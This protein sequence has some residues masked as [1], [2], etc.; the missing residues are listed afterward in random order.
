[1]E[2]NSLFESVSAQILPLAKR[3]APKTLDEVVGQDHILQKDKFLYR[4]IKADR[5]GSLIFYG[6]PGVGKTALAKVI[7]N[8]T[9]SYFRQINAVSSG[10]KDMED[11]VSFAKSEFTL[12]GKRT[13]LFI[14]EIHRFNKSQ[15]DYLLPFVENGV[16]TL[17]GATTENPYFEVNKAL[18][19]R[20]RVVELNP[21]KKEDIRKI[22]DRALIDKEDGLGNMDITMDDTAKDFLSDASG[23]DARSALNALE[24]AAMTTSPDK[25]SKKII[26]TLEI[27]SE[28]LGKKPYLYDKDGDTHYDCISAFI[29]SMRGSDENAAVYYLARMLTAGEDV[30]FIARRMMILASEDIGL[31]DPLAIIVA[32]NVAQAVERV[33]MPEAQIILSEGV[34]YLA[35][36]KKSNKAVVAISN[37]MAEVEQSGNLPVPNHLR[38]S[39]YP[40]SKELGRGIGYKYPHD[41]KDSKVDQ[42]YLPDAIKDKKFS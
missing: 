24:L 34:L 29:K 3:L 7:A 14:D 33:G 9:K 28:C 26:I 11:V 31:A 13:T 32:T 41:Y 23:G 42:Q 40:G 25:K 8:T 27:I 1:M 10:K 37:A 35:R 2:Q 15:Q 12:T 20:A 19:S 39:H 16:I 38:D 5:V 36:T 18:L 4:A 17:I 30:K 21:L 6:P 22:I